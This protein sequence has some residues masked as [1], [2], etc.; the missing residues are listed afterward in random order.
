MRTAAEYATQKQRDCYAETDKA[1]N[2][3]YAIA[4]IMAPQNKLDYFSGEDWNGPYR[5]Q[6]RESPDRYL[7]HT[8]SVT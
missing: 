5:K 4:T 7:S 8:S 6:Y 2:D 1:H 3:L